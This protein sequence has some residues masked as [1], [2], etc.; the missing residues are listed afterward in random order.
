MNKLKIKIHQISGV[1]K[2]YY[3]DLR[4]NSFKF[5]NHRKLSIK[6]LSL[7]ESYR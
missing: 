5:V 1:L 6:R 2:S 3:H 4:R 7:I